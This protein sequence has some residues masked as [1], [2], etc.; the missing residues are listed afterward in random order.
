MQ[1]RYLI[2]G[3]TSELAVAL[4]NLISH[5]IHCTLIAR[6]TDK[7][8]TISQTLRGNIDTY[9]CDLQNEIEV[10][11]LIKKLKSTQLKFDGVFCAAGAHAIQPLR[12]C[13]KTKL[14]EMMDSNFYTVANILTSISGILNP[15]ASIVVTSSAVTQRGA[16]M[17]AGYAASKAAIEALIR[18]AALEFAP[19]KIRVNAIAPGVFQSKM[20]AT[21]Q[22]SLNAS[23]QKALDANHPLGIGTTT[24]VATCVKF[25]LSSD[26]KWMTG[27]TMIVDG[28]YTINA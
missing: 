18:S 17:V 11:A 1:N 27:Q 14:N 19:K 10:K 4:I 7:L 16:N 15:Q 9:L 24:D 3:A 6:D 5:S 20:S 26:S 28:G 21:F 13:T 8:H 23:Q 2:C 22:H 12:L 25:L